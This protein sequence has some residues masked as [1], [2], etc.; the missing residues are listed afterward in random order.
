MKLKMKSLLGVAMGCL[1]LFPVIAK[2]QSSGDAC[3]VNAY[4][5]S[6]QSK[7]GSGNMILGRFTA[8]IGR[9][10]TL[11]TFKLGDTD[12]IVTVGVEYEYDNI[13]SEKPPTSIRLAI[14]ALLKEEKNLFGSTES[15]QAVTAHGKKW[16]YLSVSKNVRVENLVWTV[17]LNCES[18]KGKSKGSKL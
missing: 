16:S 10:S 12:L 1:L 2:A 8:K 14:A 5:W 18:S 11:R 17:H 7:I 3:W 13:F 9:E 15:S 4:W 6:D